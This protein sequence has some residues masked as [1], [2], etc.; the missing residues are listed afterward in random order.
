MT[1]D[2]VHRG[3]KASRA[4]V[5]RVELAAANRRIWELETELEPVRNSVA[6]F[7]EGCAQ[8]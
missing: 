2:L 3:E 7:D 8:R 1:R 6:L 4:T 5:E